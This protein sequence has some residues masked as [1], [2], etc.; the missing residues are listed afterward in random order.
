M[1]ESL[2]SATAQAR[3]VRRG[4]V[5][6]TALVDATLDR[7][8]ARNDELNAFITVIEEAAREAA[9]QAEREL[10]TSGPRGPLHGVPIA[11]KD[12]RDEK[13]GVRHTLGSKL[14]ADAGKVSDRTTAVV[15][16]LE[17]AGAIVVGKTNVPEFGHKGITDNLLMGPT[18]SPLD[19]G[20]TAGGSSGGSGAAVG[21]GMVPI[22]TGSDSGGSIRL[23][24]T[25]CGIFGL[26]PSFGVLPVDSRPNGFGHKL[27][28][29]VQ[30][31][32]TRHVEDAALCMD[33]ASGYHPRDT[34]S[35]PTD[36]DFRQS[37]GAPIDDLR[38][39]YC[40]DLAVF[41]VDS[42]IIDRTDHMV[43][44]LRAAG[45]TVERVSIDHGYSLDALVDAVK[46]TFSAAVAG[47]IAVFESET[48][49]RLEDHSANVSE[50]LYTLLELAEQQSL[51]AVPATGPLRTRLFDA[52]EDC[53]ENYDLLATATLATTD[54]DIA[55]YS[56][57]EW[58]RAL[59]WP[60]NW[61]GHPAASVPAGVTRDGGPAAL[62]LVGPRYRD[63]TVL[64]AS[65]ALERRRPWTEGLPSLASPA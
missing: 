61:T 17:S 2:T 45:A 26:K 42:A 57:L 24:A 59:T 41:P 50:T 18:R 46:T 6:P 21:A 39:A 19:P 3:A 43:E 37:L 4:D 36:L 30:G 40:P 47:G 44:G 31:P 52:I 22:A 48:G 23:P 20:W 53:F 5:T 29:S 28:H 58:E 60:F 13:A 10:A 56:G 32:L 51:G 8:A 15:A 63:P 11:I 62:Q 35:V 55:T 7:I 16:R 33:V 34:G 27:H 64:A 49:I 1:P 25:A 54:L 38:I 9:A 12:L 65:H 14:V